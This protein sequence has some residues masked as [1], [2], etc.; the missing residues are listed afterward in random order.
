MHRPG[1]G[2]AAPVRPAPRGPARGGSRTFFSLIRD[3]TGPDR[4]RRAPGSR[5]SAALPL[6]AP[7]LF[8]A[9]PIRPPAIGSRLGSQDPGKQLTFAHTGLLR[10]RQPCSQACV[11]A[12]ARS[13]RPS[14]CAHHLSSS[15][16]L[17]YLQVGS[18][19]SREACVVAAPGRPTM[20]PDTPLTPSRRPA[21][22]PTPRFQA[23]AR[24]TSDPKAANNPAPVGPRHRPPPA[25]IY[26][27]P[28]H[29]LV[30]PW[31]ATAVLL[32][33]LCASALCMLACFGLLSDR[34]L[35]S[36]STLA[37]QASDR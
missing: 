10:V 34:M 37:P 4:T 15:V 24:S 33:C 19:G 12:P 27:R 32:H 7:A 23:P 9:S 36:V 3:R 6:P 30:S 14:L 35:G 17:I 5:G 25:A 2:P 21:L 28:A 11:P 16:V 18:P 8:R 22:P 29:C 31:Q 1:P 26:T 20:A 13:A